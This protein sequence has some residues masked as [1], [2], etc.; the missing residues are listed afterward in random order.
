MRPISIRS[1]DDARVY[2]EET[3]LKMDQMSNR[4][5]RRHPWVRESYERAESIGLSAIRKH[6]VSRNQIEAIENIFTS[7]SRA[8]EGRR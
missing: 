6:S 5:Q 8:F 1:F 4:I 2:I 7:V 3:L